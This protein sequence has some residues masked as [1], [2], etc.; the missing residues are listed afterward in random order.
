MASLGFEPATFQLIAFPIFKETGNDMAIA[1][2]VSCGDDNCWMVN[3]S[4]T[5]YKAVG[6]SNIFTR[7]ICDNFA[8]G[9]NLSWLTGFTAQ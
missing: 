2:N 8:W 6:C 7:T 4:V 5:F 1:P 9:Y 3:W